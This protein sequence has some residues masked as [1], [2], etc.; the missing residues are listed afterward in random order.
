MVKRSQSP[1]FYSSQERKKPAVVKSNPAKVRQYSE[2][3]E[4]KRN[5]SSNENNAV[6]YGT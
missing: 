1:L 4:N 6:E 3:K 2:N 5:F